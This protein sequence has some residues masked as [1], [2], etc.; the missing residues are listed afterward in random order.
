MSIE[1]TMVIQEA[2]LFLG[3]GKIEDGRVVGAHEAISS[4]SSREM[5]GVA[6]R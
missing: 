5:Q 6:A 3:L 1:W 4:K 2:E